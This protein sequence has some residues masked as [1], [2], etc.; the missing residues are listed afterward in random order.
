MGNFV[1]AGLA[2]H[3]KLGCPAAVVFIVGLDANLLGLPISGR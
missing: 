2:M 3:S 1:P